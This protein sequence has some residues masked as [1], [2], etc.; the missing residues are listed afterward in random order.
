MFGVAILSTAPLHVF[1]NN[2]HL[3]LSVAYLLCFSSS[4]FCRCVPVAS[5]FI[6]TPMLENVVN[7]MVCL[8]ASLV[9]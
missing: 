8:R 6:P 3:R 2:S 9:V 5:F 1:G 7:E 4:L